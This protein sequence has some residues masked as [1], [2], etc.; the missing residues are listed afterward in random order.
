MTLDTSQDD[1]T[2]ETDILNSLA[3]NPMV[4]ADVVQ[5][6]V[7]PML[8]SIEFKRAKGKCIMMVDARGFHA[9]LD[10]LGVEYDTYSRRYKEAPV[11]SDRVVNTRDHELSPWVFLQRP[12]LGE[13]C[14]EF[15]LMSS[16][17]IPPTA[18]IL[19]A[20]GDSVQSVLDWIVDH[21]RPVE[22]RVNVLSKK[23]A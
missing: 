5:P 9:Y 10:R 22:I 4:P 7:E 8:V 15:D 3:G 19:R 16:Y 21:Y 2:A 6:S 12:G 13:S 14:V 11:S 17:T 1:N 20:L 18:T 23:G